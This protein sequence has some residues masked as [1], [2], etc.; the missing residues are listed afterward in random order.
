MPEIRTG[1]R[2]ITSR[3]AQTSWIDFRHVVAVGLVAE[4]T[5]L[6]AR[7]PHD[8]SAT[9]LA[10]GRIQVSGEV[11]DSPSGAGKSVRGGA[12]NGWQFWILP[13]GR[14]LNSLKE[15]YLRL[16]EARRAAARDDAEG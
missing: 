8:A 7:S 1:T 10:D 12:T 9:V 14:R 3:E 15:P 5:R 2:V 13:D 6:R 4:G 11:F 16:L